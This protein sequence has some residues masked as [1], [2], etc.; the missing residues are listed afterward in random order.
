MKLL[1]FSEGTTTNGD[2]VIDF[3]KGAFI[4]NRPISLL[5]LRYKGSF[6]NGFTLFNLGGHIIG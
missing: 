4:L 1:I 5:G 2:G 3:K 6:G